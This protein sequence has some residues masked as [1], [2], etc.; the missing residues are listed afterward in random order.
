MTE[1]IEH[2]RWAFKNHEV[3]NFG[4]L[5]GKDAFGIYFALSISANDLEK[6]NQCGLK[7]HYVKTAMD[8]THLIALVTER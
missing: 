4:H 7:L 6:I 5:N 8:E 1:I 3:G 2:I